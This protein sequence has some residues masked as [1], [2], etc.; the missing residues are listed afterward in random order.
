MNSRTSEPQVKRATEG[1][2]GELEA[3][4]SEDGKDINIER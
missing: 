2:E 4:E 3:E 1:S